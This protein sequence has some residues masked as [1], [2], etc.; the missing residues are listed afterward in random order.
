M[1]VQLT[2]LKTEHANPIVFRIWTI[3]LHRDE[4]LLPPLTVLTNA[5][6]VIYCQLK[7]LS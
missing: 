2:S 7:H 1:M 6:L 3:E 5:C 4:H